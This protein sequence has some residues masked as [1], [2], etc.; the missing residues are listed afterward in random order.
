M[1]FT[2]TAAYKCPRCY[3]RQFIII[4]INVEK[5][6]KCL[7]FVSIFLTWQDIIG[8]IIKYESLEKIIIP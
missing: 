2:L 1:K 3:F 7:C 4:I 5:L 6:N 8:M